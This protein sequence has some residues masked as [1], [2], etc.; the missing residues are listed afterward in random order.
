[1][2]TRKILNILQEI[3]GRATP[4]DLDDLNKY[5]SE[6]KGENIDMLDMDIIHLIRA[7]NKMLG[8]TQDNQMVQRKLAVIQKNIDDIKHLTQGE[9]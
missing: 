2:Q 5:F 1:M 4:C 8:S 7:F 3:D 6:T 9:V